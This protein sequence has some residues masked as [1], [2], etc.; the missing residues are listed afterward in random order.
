MGDETLPSESPVGGE[1][2]F[3]RGARTWPTPC[4]RQGGGGGG[5][6]GRGEGGRRRDPVTPGASGESRR[7]RAELIDASPAGALQRRRA[8]GTQK[9]PSTPHSQTNC[10]LTA[11]RLSQLNRLKANGS[12]G[13]S[14]RSSSNPGH[15]PHHR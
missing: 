1:G 4:T 14:Q 6:R 5:E 15:A 8:G 13:G 12:G 11:A 9:L 10:D 7:Q 3:E 2:N